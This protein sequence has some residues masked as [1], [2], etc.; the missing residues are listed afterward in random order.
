M[1]LNMGAVVGGAWKLWRSERALLLPIAGVFLMLPTVIGTVWMVP[2]PAATDP[3]APADLA[4]LVE[5]MQGYVSANLHW[6]LLETVMGLFGM[7]VILALFLDGSRPTVAEAMRVALRRFPALLLAQIVCQFA[8][9]LG[10]LAFLIPGLYAVGR[11]FLIPAAIIAEPRRG[12]VDAMARGLQ[13]TAGNGL[14]LLGLQAMF[15]F[16]AQVVIALASTFTS[17]GQGNP[18]AV[19]V[20]ALIA[21]AANGGMALAY[22]LLRVTAY[23]EATA[24]RG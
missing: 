23:R 22:A 15:Y 9:V 20:G 5:G 3:A 7:G 21:G 8:V 2:P 16:A 19:A 14:A 13:L 1:K 11:I 10:L 18:V 6:L 24:S 4:T 12:A 17:L